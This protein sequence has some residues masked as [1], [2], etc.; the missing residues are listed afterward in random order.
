MRR[1]WSSRRRG[2]TCPCAS[3]RSRAAR[4]SFSLTRR[5]AR[6]RSRQRL[7]PE[8]SPRSPLSSCH[9]SVRRRRR[10]R[11]GRRTQGG[12]K[13]GLSCARLRAQLPPST[14]ICARMRG[15]VRRLRCWRHARSRH[16]ARPRM[17]RGCGRR[18][19]TPTSTCRGAEP[20]APLPAASSGAARRSSASPHRVGAA[21][22]TGLGARRGE[23]GRERDG[24]DAAPCCEGYHGQGAYDRGSELRAL[25]GRWRT[26]P[27]A[28][29]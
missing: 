12:H 19:S 6:P 3:R 20:K 23:G 22:P 13:R 7:P 29:A 15:R 26:H 9:P 24:E 28:P 21:A 2:G 4:R 17:R 16:A 10:R 8:R 18:T 14:S 11:T 25:C 5:R 27:L 1:R